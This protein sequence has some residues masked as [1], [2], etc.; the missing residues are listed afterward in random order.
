MYMLE[1][2]RVERLIVNWVGSGPVVFGRVEDFRFCL[3]VSFFSFGKTGIY[4]SNTGTHSAFPAY[5]QQPRIMH[6]KYR[7]VCK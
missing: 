7:D 3:V 1:V 4:Q 5:Y 2:G 6:T